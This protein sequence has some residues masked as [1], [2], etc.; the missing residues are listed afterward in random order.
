MNSKEAY[1]PV[2][3]VE[4]VV[5]QND[6]NFIKFILPGGD[7]QLEVLKNEGDYISALDLG[8]KLPKGYLLVRISTDREPPGKFGVDPR[9]IETEGMYNPA[10]I[11]GI[12]TPSVPAA[13]VFSSQPQ[14]NTE[15]KPNPEVFRHQPQEKAG[16]F[17]R[18][19]FKEKATA[20]DN[21]AQTDKGDSLGYFKALNLNASDLVGLT[22]EEVSK[23][24]R[25]SY[26]AA[27]SVAHPDH[28]G[29]HNAMVKVNRAME[30]ISN[31]SLRSAYQHQTGLFAPQVKA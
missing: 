7:Y 17:N 23:K 12:I 8:S 16:N 4:G 18:N 21:F 25:S 5:K 20:R 3:T 19:T 31:P 29:N 11:S 28:G 14:N 24:I 22:N 10:Q 1:R 15:T 27:A 30:V 13:G 9:K 6:L 26:R 2:T